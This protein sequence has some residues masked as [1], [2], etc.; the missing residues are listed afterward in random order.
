MSLAGRKR[1]VLA[2]DLTPALLENLAD[3]VVACDA[4]GRIVVLN[5]LA[6]D[7]LAALGTPIDSWAPL[8]RALRGED[9]VNEQVEI[10]PPHGPVLLLNVSGGPLRDRRGRVDGAV[11]VMQD[12]TERVAMDNELR[13]QSAIAEKMAEGIALIRASDGIIVYAN[14]RW[15]GIF[16]ARR[17]ELLGQ[18]ISVVNAPTEQA[19][20]ERAQEI[21]GALERD[22]VWSG[23]LRNVRRDGTLIWTAAQISTFEHR[24]HGTVWISAQR[25]V[26][27]EKAAQDAL[28]EAEQRFRGV[29][30]H[31]PFGI[32]LIGHDLLVNETNRAFGE[33]TGYAPEELSG[34][35]LPDL[36][37]P[38]HG[39]LADQLA[40][41]LFNGHRPHRRVA[42]RLVT[43]RGDTV[44]VAITGTTVHGAD[45][46]PLYGIAVVQAT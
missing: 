8:T 25:D 16:G 44:P 23:E 42:A 17:G 30:E 10:R 3:A 46:R 24:E 38:D 31:S 15:E 43:K 6:R 13:L 1:A 36:A 14:D 9:V 28:R 19:P 2:A 12:I 40:P 32:A 41:V 29:F 37:V 7:H 11:V 21:I 5:R 4:D 20:E 27:P 45:G 22:G 34:R 35:R 18:H 33:I 26:T 39:R